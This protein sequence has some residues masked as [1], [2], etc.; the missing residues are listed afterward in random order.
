MDKVNVPAW[1]QGHMVKNK[2]TKV[3]AVFRHFTYFRE[4]L[5]QFE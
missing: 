2:F 1:P 3:I 5:L 4:L